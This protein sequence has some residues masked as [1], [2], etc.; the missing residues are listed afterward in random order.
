M[1]KKFTAI[2]L[3][4][5]FTQVYAVTPVLNSNQ[6]DH[7]LGKTFDELN[8]KLNVEWDQKDSAFFDESMK[9]VE[10]DID[11]LAAQGLSTEELIEYTIKRV[12][13]KESKRELYEMTRVISENQ[14]SPIEA[15][16]FII[17][18]MNNAYA[19][20]A[21]WNGAKANPTTIILASII[22]VVVSVQFAATIIMMKRLQDEIDK[23]TAQIP[24][25]YPI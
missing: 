3:I 4:S 13:D 9:K 5:A 20:G 7:Q 6:F 19:L 18:K 11:T 2:I 12:K 17:S 10:S 15:R 1:L 21:S 24:D 8:Y 14:M 22:L 25:G 23:Q 16:S